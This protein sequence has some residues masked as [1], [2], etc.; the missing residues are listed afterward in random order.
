MK[1]ILPVMAITLLLQ[2]CATTSR[3]TGVVR[4][5]DADYYY[6]DWHSL[7]SQKAFDVAAAPKEGMAAFISHL[8]YPPGLRQ[9]RVGGEVRVLVSLDS[10][11]RVLEARIVQ[12]AH[13]ILDRMVVDAIYQSRW[14]P[15]LK[16]GVPIPL[17]FYLPVAF[18]P[19]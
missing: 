11:G 15:A 16:N 9:Q 3:N 1:I 18:A 7:P 6:T 10:T 13:P 12:S 2:S 17:K 19:P 14:T 5:T 4:R 8:R